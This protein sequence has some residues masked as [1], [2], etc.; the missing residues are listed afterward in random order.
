MSNITPF[1]VYMHSFYHPVLSFLNCKYFFKHHSWCYSNLELWLQS[2]VI[3]W[4][5]CL[6]I[7]T[8]F[9]NMIWYTIQSL[10][11]TYELYTIKSG[12]NLS[13]LYNSRIYNWHNHIHATCLAT[14][15]ISINS[16]NAVWI[17]Y[18]RNALGIRSISLFLKYVQITEFSAIRTQS[19]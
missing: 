8:L 17:F 12:L 6:N 15:K 16:Q 18:N 13:Y 14:Q 9:F 19:R 11:N 7:L 5:F 1:V 4:F 3:S 2:E 10:E